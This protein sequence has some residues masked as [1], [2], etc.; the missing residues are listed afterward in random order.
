MAAFV[1]DAMPINAAF[2]NTV[3]NDIVAEHPELWSGVRFCI[4]DDPICYGLRIISIA[5]STS[6]KCY[7]RKSFPSFKASLRIMHVHML[8]RQ[9]EAPVQP[10]ACN[11]FLVLLIRRIC[12]LLNT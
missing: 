6:V 5:T 2:Q 9:F 8:Q 1:L 7:S 3:P 12:H 4:M 10:N 11:L